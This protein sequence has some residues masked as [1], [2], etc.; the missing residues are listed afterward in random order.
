[1]ASSIG[2]AVQ[3][4]REG[5]WTPLVE[6]AA[7]APGKNW[8]EKAQ[9]SGRMADTFFPTA[10][11]PWS[12]PDQ[13]RHAQGI[14]L[15]APLKLCATCPLAVAARCLVESLRSDDEY[16]IRAGLLASERSEL[17]RS[18]K[19]RLD[20]TAISAAL[21]GVTTLLS[22]HERQ[23]VV[24]RFAADPM[25]GADRVARGLGVPSKYLW[26]LAREHKQRYAPATSPAPTSPAS[27]AA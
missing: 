1:M 14:A 4:A 6:A 3:A 21:R 18:W 8:A 22:A 2:V 15:N 25:I 9:C 13:V 20:S 17:R 10:E 26:Q 19:Q 5:N 12:D 7:D 23:E 27:K 24:A 16:G 11:H